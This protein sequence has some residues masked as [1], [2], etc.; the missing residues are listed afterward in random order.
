MEMRVSV[1]AMA[2]SLVAGMVLIGSRA[3]ADAIPILDNYYYIQ[4]STDPN[5]DACNVVASGVTFD[6]NGE[7]VGTGTGTDFIA[8]LYDTQRPTSVSRTSAKINIKQSSFSTLSVQITA[9]TSGNNFVTGVVAVEKCAVSGSVN[10]TKMTGSV[11]ASCSGSGLFGGLTASQAASMQ[12]AFNSSKTASFKA[13][14]S[15][16]W[17][18]KIKCSGNAS[19]PA[20]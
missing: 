20:P 4:S 11:T 17:T 7:V 15:G 12:A 5:T 13:D 16:K 9:S 19:V 8:V 3:E 10:G 1:F 6:T 18:L 2:T 14:S